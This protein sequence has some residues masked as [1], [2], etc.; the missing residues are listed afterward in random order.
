MLLIQFTE[1]C[2][3]NSVGHLS[4]AMREMERDGW[5]KREGE[6][7]GLFNH[8]SVSFFFVYNFFY[9]KCVQESIV[10]KIGYPSYFPVTRR[11]KVVV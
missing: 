11:R 7:R 6:R 9:C 10:G 8:F 1:Y 3:H 4:A 5:K 2:D